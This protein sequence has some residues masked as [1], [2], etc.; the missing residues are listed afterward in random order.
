MKKLK[1]WQI[2]LIV[3]VVIGII[4][5]VFGGDDSEE[6]NPEEKL[7]IEWNEEEQKGYV[8]FEQ[9]LDDPYVAK[10]VISNYYENITSALE[11]VDK[12]SLK[13]YEY[14]EFKAELVNE[15]GKV[16]GVIKGDLPIEFIKGYEDFSKAA[17]Q[18][19]VED[20][21]ENLFI[22]KFLEE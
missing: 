22:P 10:F 19:D 1:K 11:T 2:V 20:N 14:I 3:I 18:L 17:A 4:G 9:E 16:A 5:A 13:D 21:M 15:D 7:A 6:T 12:E 8:E